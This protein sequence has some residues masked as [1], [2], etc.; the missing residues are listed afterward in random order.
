MKPAPFVARQAG[1][2]GGVG[3]V[4]KHD[5]PWYSYIL[6]GATRTCTA[7][8]MEVDTNS[9][10]RNYPLWTSYPG[11]AHRLAESEYVGT[12]AMAACGY[13]RS[14]L[15]L[16]LLSSEEVVTP[17]LGNNTEMYP[18]LKSSVEP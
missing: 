13:T 9:D 7:S 2:D 4:T 18:S 11:S 12:V 17:R 15:S 3:V 1:V 6:G 16:S 5:G 14:N 8:K 10:C